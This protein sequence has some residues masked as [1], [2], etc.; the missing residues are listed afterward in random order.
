[1]ADFFA[2]GKKPINGYGGG[3]LASKSDLTSI[4]ES[5]TT[6]SRAIS[7]GTYFYLD[8][9]LVQAKTD[10]VNGATFTLNT[11]YEVV[12]GAL[13]M[14]KLY[15]TPFTTKT[16]SGGTLVTLPLPKGKY[17]FWEENSHSNNGSGTYCVT[18]GTYS[19]DVQ[20]FT[21]DNDTTFTI[22]SPTGSS[23][24]WTNY[25]AFCLKVR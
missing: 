10:I 11:N 4:F 18:V 13:C 22:N 17:I 7:A 12:N 2:K 20:N 1:M 16:I 14:P 24:T 5:G 15:A 6:A 21:L 8:G 23:Q 9:T 25:R 3:N 19:S